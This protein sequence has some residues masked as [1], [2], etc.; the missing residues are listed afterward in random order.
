ME[1]NSLICRHLVRFQIYTIAAL[2]AYRQFISLC[3]SYRYFGVVFGHLDHAGP[4][5]SFNFYILTVF[6]RKSVVSPVV[7]GS[8]GGGEQKLIVRR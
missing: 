6:C 5:L 8:I 1:S 7:D 3:I 4:P 2:A